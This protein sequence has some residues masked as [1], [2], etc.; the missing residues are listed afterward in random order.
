VIT[1]AARVIGTKPGIKTASSFFMMILNDRSFGH[2]GILVFADCAL[3]PDPD[4]ETLADIALA[5]AD[6]AKRIIGLE[7]KVAMLSF[8]TKGTRN[9]NC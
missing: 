5:T 4:A 2:E 6:S 3:I 8:S 9:M 7:P 1:A